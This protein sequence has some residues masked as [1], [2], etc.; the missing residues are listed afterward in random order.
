MS[1]VRPTRDEET[2][3]STTPDKSSTKKEERTPFFSE[4]EKRIYGWYGFTAIMVI[5]MIGG[6]F[7]AALTFTMTSSSV[8]TTGGLTLLWRIPLGTVWIVWTLAIWYKTA[9]FWD[10]ADVEWVDTLLK[11]VRHYI[12]LPFQS[13]RKPRLRRK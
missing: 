1:T 8:P 13:F 11:N 10:P 5:C 7:A 9:K 6:V 4:T 3:M 12:K 2:H